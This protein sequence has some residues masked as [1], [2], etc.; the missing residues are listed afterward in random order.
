MPAA[1]LVALIAE[2]HKI[3]TFSYPIVSGINY[4]WRNH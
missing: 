3:K 1:I 2:K 4:F